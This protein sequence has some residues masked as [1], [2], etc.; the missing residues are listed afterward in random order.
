MNENQHTQVL[1]HLKNRGSITS[2]DAFS[3]YHITRLSSIIYNLRKRGYEIH[4]IM[5]D[6]KSALGASC[7]Y[8]KY[9]YVEKENK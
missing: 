5:I 6:G 9:L 8:A 7:K 1:A 2:M 3:D 4:T